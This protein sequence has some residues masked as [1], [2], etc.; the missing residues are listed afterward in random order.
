[1]LKGDGGVIWNVTLALL[2]KSMSTAD[3]FATTDPM[4]AASVIEIS[5]WLPNAGV[6]LVYS[7][8]MGALSLMSVR[9]TMTV[10]VALSCG[11]PRLWTKTVTE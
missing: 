6:P 3:T 7:E 11:L 10:S 5:N 2:P 9:Y 1:M 8:R 4:P